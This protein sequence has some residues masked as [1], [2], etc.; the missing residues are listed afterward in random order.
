MSFLE[1]TKMLNEKLIID[2]KKL[3]RDEFDNKSVNAKILPYYIDP[4]TLELKII[5]KRELV[6]SGYLALDR[7]VALNAIDIELPI[8]KKLTIEEVFGLLNIEADVQQA[9]PVGSLMPFPKKTT[10]VFEMILLHISPPAFKDE[11]NNIVCINDKERYEL[12]VLNFNETMDA[13]ENNLIIDLSVR[14]LLNELYIL[15]T[16]YS[17]NDNINQEGAIGV[18]DETENKETFFKEITKNSVKTT[19]IP[20]EIIEK[21]KQTDFGKKFLQ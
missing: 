12:G 9:I 8:D 6:E 21:N 18:Y 2:E 15:A 11:K 14:L 16:E 4:K 17:E 1:T 19:D 20:D 5:V 3:K 13:I 10:D 7:K